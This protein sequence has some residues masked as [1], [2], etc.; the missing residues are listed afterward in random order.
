M[1]IGVAPVQGGERFGETREMVTFADENGI[2]SVFFTEHHE[3]SG[4]H[5]PDP[6]GMVTAMAERTDDVRL[7]TGVLL[8]PLYNPVRLAERTAMADGISG[9]RLI[10]AA[11]V[12]YRE[13][14]FELFD[15]PRRH[16]GAIYEEYLELVSRAWSQETVTFDGDHYSV[17]GYACRP[18]PA[19]SPRPDIWIGG[20]ADPVIDRAARFIADDLAD[21]WFPGAQ[22]DV[23]GL[24][25]R[26]DT[27]ERRL[28]EHDLVPGDVTQP[29]LRDGVLA[30][31]TEEAVEVARDHLIP[32]YEKY[33]ANVGREQSEHEDLFPALVSEEFD[34]EE[35][36]E[37]HLWVGSPADWLEKFDRLRDRM[38]IDHA[39]FRIHFEGMDHAF[40]MRQLELLCDEVIPSM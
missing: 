12:G 17:D 6:L 26:H 25:A 28:G 31:T 37:S 13:R 18:S 20:Y 24:A 38:A 39:V 35:L 36:I 34:P 7:G 9:G 14:E 29:V 27:F 33:Y 2:D 32:S 10:F 4:L 5:W 16:R 1:D 40:N 3:D 22:P 19:S 30:P 21:T 11:G 23:D 8:L 15:V